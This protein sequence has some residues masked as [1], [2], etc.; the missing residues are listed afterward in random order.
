MQIC[1][2]TLAQCNEP[3]T[4]PYKFDSFYSCAITG[5]SVARD[6]T[7]NMQEEYVNKN[8]LVINFTCKESMRA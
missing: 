8:K 6:I 5:Y 4:Y 7:Y 3:I 1:L 2:P